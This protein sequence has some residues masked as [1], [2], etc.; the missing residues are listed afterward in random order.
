MLMPCFQ[1]CVFVKISD[2]L[3]KV[4]MQIAE[5]GRVND[6]EGDSASLGS[7]EI[8]CSVSC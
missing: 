4:G 3:G 8:L 6:K 5:L 1:L 2:S 7:K